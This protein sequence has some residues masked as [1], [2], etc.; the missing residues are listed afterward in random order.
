MSFKCG[1]IELLKPRGLFVFAVLV[2]QEF[3]V[4]FEIPL[5]CASLAVWLQKTGKWKCSIWQMTNTAK[6]W[7][8]CET[9]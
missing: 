6:K 8:I 9:A 7:L 2:L 4:D 1:E 3:C 5:F